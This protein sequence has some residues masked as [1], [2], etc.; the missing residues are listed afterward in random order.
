MSRRWAVASLA[1]TAAAGA[2]GLG[3]H[4]LLRRP[5]PRTRGVLRFEGLDGEIEILRDPWGVPHIYASNS[6]DLFFAQGFVHA[7]DRLWQ[8]ELNRRIVA[9]RLSEV[10][11]PRSV[12]VDRWVRT[13][14]M[15]R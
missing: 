3:Y 7:Q 11:G 4:W 1:L 14:G 5:L 8:M 15:R 12:P 10:I 2:V 9:G 13:L 6:H